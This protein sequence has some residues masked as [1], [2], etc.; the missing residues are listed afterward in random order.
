MITA[1]TQ[2][3]TYHFAPQCEIITGDRHAF[4]KVAF[5][6]SRIVGSCNLVAIVFHQI[7]VAETGDFDA[8]GI[9]FIHFIHRQNRILFRERRVFPHE[10]AFVIRSRN[11]LHHILVIFIQERGAVNFFV[12]K[13]FH[14]LT[15]DADFLYRITFRGDQF[16]NGGV[17][18]FQFIIGNLQPD[19]SH[20]GDPFD[21]ITACQYLV[22]I[23][24]RRDFLLLQ[25]LG[26]H[27]D[28][29]HANIAIRAFDDLFIKTLGF[30]FIVSPVPAVNMRDRFKFT[31]F[32]L[33]KRTEFCD[34]V[35]V[36]KHLF[37][38]RCDL[39]KFFVGSKFMCFSPNRTEFMP[40]FLLHFA[41][42]FGFCFSR[43]FRLLFRSLF[44]LCAKCG[45][46]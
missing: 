15:I 40:E 2:N 9:K 1:E 35:E 16:H 8:F 24:L 30:G 21:L 33:G 27:F 45:S 42:S 11:E 44:C 43:S 32:I 3:R 14:E 38:I 36:H 29:A 34:F 5:H 37:A 17:G 22:D 19:Q 28:P 25:E 12:L 26:I 20:I 18:V 10:S 46:E 31:Q 39:G 7:F 41:V 23:F 6:R 4:I 13:I